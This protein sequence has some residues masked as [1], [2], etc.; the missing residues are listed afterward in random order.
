MTF[1]DKIIMWTEKKKFIDALNK[2]F[3]TRPAGSAIMGVT[4]EVYQKDFSDQLG[5]DE[6]L[7]VEYDGG[8]KSYM[9][10]SGNS[11]LANFEVI[12]KVL[13]HGDYHLKE[14]Y[15]SLTD[16]GWEPVQLRDQ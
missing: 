4:Y 16:N 9:L 10:V 3:Q 6:W 15:K 12:S 1:E 11:N 8:A 13:F 7:I 14:Y 5:Y 2:V